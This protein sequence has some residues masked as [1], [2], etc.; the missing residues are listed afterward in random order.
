MK[1]SSRWWEIMV[2]RKQMGKNIAK[3]NMCAIMNLEVD[4]EN[5]EEIWFF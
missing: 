5:K 1:K 3:N 2:F 4:Y